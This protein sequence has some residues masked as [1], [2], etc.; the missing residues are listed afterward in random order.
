VRFDV[1]NTAMTGINTTATFTTCARRGV[2]L[3]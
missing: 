1:V 2:R 3:I